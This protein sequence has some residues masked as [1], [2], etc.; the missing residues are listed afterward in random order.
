MRWSNASWR[1]ELFSE[2]TLHYSTYGLGPDTV[3]KIEYLWNL[4]VDIPRFAASIQIF[5]AE[6]SICF[7]I[8]SAP[9]AVQ[10]VWCFNH[11]CS[12]CLMVK[13][14]INHS[15]SWFKPPFVTNLSAFP[16]VIHLHFTPW[17]FWLQPPAMTRWGCRVRTRLG[18]L[19][20]GGDPAGIAI[21]I[22][23]LP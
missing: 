15:F 6:I 20:A 17:S 1:S 12:S 22:V 7:N 13:F 4:R 8:F 14:S 16:L 9:Q 10:C 5:L 19:V 18:C 23:D 11:H 2:I 3:G 21:E